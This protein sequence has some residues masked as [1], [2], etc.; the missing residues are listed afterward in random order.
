MLRI[1]AGERL[2]GALTAC[3]LAACALAAP[4]PAAAQGP[5]HTVSTYRVPVTQPDE[6]GQPVALD[7][8]VYLPTAP[9]PRSGRPLVMIFHGGGSDKANGYDSGHA[10]ALADHGYAVILYSARGHG[11]S[12]GQTTVIGPKEVRDIYDVA[13]WAFA[14]GGRTSPAH[15]AFRLDRARIAF[16]GYSQG[17]LHTNLG[18]VWNGDRSIDPYGLHVRALEPGNTPDETFEALVDRG[19]VKLSFGV[20]LL[21]TY[22]VG[23]KAHIAPEVYRWVATA[24]ADQ[25]ALYGGA[26]CD[27]SGHDTPTATMKADLAWRSPGCRASRMGLPWLWAQ[28]FDD[29]LFTP[30][31]AIAMW[32]RAPRRSRHRLYLSMGGHAAPAAPSAV[33][34]D[35]F[36]AQ[37]A[38]LDHALRGT[39]LRM[40]AVT[41]WVRDPAVAVPSNAYAYPAGAWYRRTAPTWPPPG[42]RPVGYQLG[43]NGRAVRSGAAAGSTL[44]AAPGE[45]EANDPVALSALA[46]TPLGTSPIPSA[47]PASNAPGLVAAFSTDPFPA[48]RELAGAPVARL[49]WTPL[50]PDTQLVLELFDR[51]PDGTMSLITRGVAGV[52]GAAPGAVQAVTVPAKTFSQLIRPGH[53][54]VAWVLAGDVGFYKPFVPPAGGVL[55]TGP[56]STLTVPLRVP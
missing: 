17:G 31:M 48:A 38:F 7:T 45:N 53:R 15:P 34:A 9:V 29:S 5:A 54:L 10:A 32:R 25:P 23:A 30:D 1:L 22:L 6:A 27:W 4:G 33:E 41:Y 18:Q 42:T 49:A 20:G 55:G 3:L 28:A 44:L 37:V 46:A 36:A 51:A 14:L 43:A 50:A 19:V 12:D 13:A 26:P 56:G 39:P 52:R 11:S 8:D 16:S 47:L 35:R 2:V 40:P 24:A 21:E